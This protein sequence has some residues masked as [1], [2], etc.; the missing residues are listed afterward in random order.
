MSTR[1]PLSL[2]RT[3]PT[4]AR[5]AWSNKGILCGPFMPVRTMSFQVRANRR[6]GSIP[7][8]T[9]VRLAQPL[10]ATLHTVTAISPICPE[11]GARQFMPS[12]TVCLS[13][14][15]R[16]RAV[17][18]QKIYPTRYRLHVP[19]IAARAILAQMVDV[20]PFRN[21]PDHQFVGDAMRFY[22]LAAKRRV[23]VAR[24]FIAVAG[25]RPTSVHVGDA[26]CDVLFDNC[27]VSIYNHR[28]H[29]SMDAAA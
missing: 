22:S 6:H 24:A 27:H 16:R 2:S 17:P 26:N 28:P 8:S 29:K 14:L 1:N 3:G 23:A 11:V 18:A 5:V 19:R 15:T 10:P 7:R 9:V 4:P 12:D 21:R 20:E 25:I 13:S